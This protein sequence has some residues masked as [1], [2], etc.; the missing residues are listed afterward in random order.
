[1]VSEVVVA[2]SNGWDVACQVL[3][4]PVNNLSTSTTATFVKLVPAAWIRPHYGEMRP[5]NLSEC[6][7]IIVDS[8]GLYK[9]NPKAARGPQWGKTHVQHRD[10]TVI[11][12]LSARAKTDKTAS[13]R[14]L[15]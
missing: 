13:H 14:A 12:G 8:R 7:R 2:R 5:A 15:W 10:E 1:M 9:V 11:T 6:S 3:R 4:L